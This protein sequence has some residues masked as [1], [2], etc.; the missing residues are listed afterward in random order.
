MI[1]NQVDCIVRFHDIKRL[2]ELDRCIFSLVGQIHRPLNIILTV[3]RFSE[4]EIAATQ[5]AL[6]A[7]L[8]LPNA[9]TLTIKNWTN[10]EPSDARTYLLNMGLISSIGQYVAFLDY[11]DVLYPEAY[12]LLI[13]RLRDS[14]AAIAFA[15][16][17]VVTAQV[18]K[19]FIRTANQLDLFKGEG[20]DDLFRGNFCPLHSYLIDRSVVSPDILL[21]DTSLTMQEDYDFLLKICSTYSS[22]FK[23]IKKI[24]GDY[25]YK[26]DGS[27]TVWVNNSPSEEQQLAYES[28][29]ALIEE[30]RRT[31]FLS[32]AVKAQLG[33][34]VKAPGISIQDVVRNRLARS[35]Q[36]FKA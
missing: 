25:Y 35:R 8:G 9:P 29:C 7:L 4:F 2:N 16:V 18:Y 14:H 10:P 26:T 28:V 20:L 17:R 27:N 34:E 11:D 13:N 12:A 31:T 5:A 1:E 3:Q 33:I 6:E 21:C 30:R 22:D 15:S 23:A 32:A 36:S 24:I 19:S